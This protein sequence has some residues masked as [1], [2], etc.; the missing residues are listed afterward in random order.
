[1]AKEVYIQIFPK[2]EEIRQYAEPQVFNQN[3]GGD[4]D[5]WEFGLS[6]DPNY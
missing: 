3:F 2:K 6:Q 1:M 5:F 4:F